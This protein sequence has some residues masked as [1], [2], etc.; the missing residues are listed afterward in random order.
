MS[1]VLAQSKERKLQASVG[2]EGIH[3]RIIYRQTQAHHLAAS[4]FSLD[5]IVEPTVQ[6]GIADTVELQP[7]SGRQR[8]KAVAKQRQQGLWLRELLHRTSLVG[9]GACQR[10]PAISGWG[11]DTA[12]RWNP[13]ARCTPS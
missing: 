5:E 13:P 11:G 10:G 2:T 4:L 9:A 6:N 3:R 12:V 7:E 8:K 1:G